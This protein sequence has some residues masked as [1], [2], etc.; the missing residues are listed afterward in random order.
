MNT[1]RAKTDTPEVLVTE[2]VAINFCS[3]LLA[4]TTDE[5]DRFYL[6]S[7]PEV[8]GFLLGTGVLRSAKDADLRLPFELAM[9]DAGTR[10]R[11]AALLEGVAHHLR[12]MPLE[13]K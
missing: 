11:L 13:A 9:E 10:S 8:D 1:A 12:N 6:P 5:D 4:A 3:L 7:D 2:Q